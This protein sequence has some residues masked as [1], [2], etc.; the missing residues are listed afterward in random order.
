MSGRGSGGDPGPAVLFSS[1]GAV[2]VL[3]GGTWAAAKLGIAFGADP[4]PIPANPLAYVIQL[5]TGSAAWPGPAATGAAIGVAALVTVLGVLVGLLVQRHRGR[6][7]S[8]DGRS[9]HLSGR[10]ESADLAPKAAERTAQ[11]LRPSGAGEG[12]SGHGI[13]LGTLVHG[14]GLT[15]SSGQPILGSYED[16]YCLI[17]G[18]RRMKSSC[19]VIP[20]A[21][22]APGAVVVTSNKRDVHDSTR[23]VRARAGA[24]WCFDPQQ[25]VGTTPDFWFNPLSEVATIDHARELAS[26]FA[27]GVR[28]A[29]AKTDAYFD[30]EAESLLGR[31][32]L[33]AARADG[34]LLDAYRW[35]QNPYDSSPVRH[36]RDAGDTAS[37]DALEATSQ[38]ADKQRDGVYGT[39]RSFV[40]CLENPTITRWVTPQ[41]G[42][43]QFDP[44][45]FVAS[46]DT[47][48]SLSEEGEGSAGPLVAAL[49]QAIFNAG[50]R[51]ATHSPG[52]RLDRPLISVLD[53]AA[54]VVRLRKLPQQYSHFGSQGLPVMTVLQSWSQGTEVWG[55]AGMKALWGA[56]TV[57]LYGGG[58]A[59]SQ[60]L[61]SLSQLIG[62]YDRDTTSYSFD[63]RGSRSRSTS[64]RRERIYSPAD[65]ASLPRGRAIGLIAGH[66]PMLLQAHPWMQGPHAAAIEASRTRWDPEQQ[67]EGAPT[68]R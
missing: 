39:A 1:L 13:E 15:S 56:S 67:R 14:S 43:V 46:A 54:N 27:M 33:A 58:A 24:I 63:G 19:Y 52:G 36:L 51:Q 18:P 59:E 65:L 12:R 31:L 25:I 53:E 4:V 34:T 60:W 3:V 11:R 8:L 22:A 41:A 30:T 55:E 40:R 57:R 16:T 49:T 7:H 21:V 66:R 23:D 5:A 35:L 26:H 68:P 2:V 29:S 20:I 44:A 38:L 37:A 61:E 45:T 50:R 42:L 62:D 6:D 28:S 48:Y 9:R 47:V 10:R 64:T 17:A 32:L